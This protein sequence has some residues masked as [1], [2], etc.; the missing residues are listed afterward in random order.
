[1]VDGDKQTYELQ[2]YKYDVLKEYSLQKEEPLLFAV[3]WRNQGIWTINSIDSFSSKSSAYKISYSN[4]CLDD[5]SAI[6]GDYTYVFKH[7]CYRKSKFS[8]RENISTEFIH[9]HE[10]YG[11]TVHES[12]SID[13]VNFAPLCMLEPAVLDCAFNFKTTSRKKIF[14]DGTELI[15][16]LDG[17]PYVYKLSSLILAYLR[18]IQCY[19]PMDMYYKSNIVV[20]N[21][22]NI[23]DTVRQKC[24]G[25]RFYLVP[26]N[27]TDTAT[28]M[29]NLHFGS[30][31]H[32]M[33]AYTATKRVEGYRIIVSHK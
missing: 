28:K 33:E 21:A 18:K 2:K 8:N 7:P 22:F 24:G 26:H 12:L 3:F 23:V 1:M 16:E 17:T 30:V 5:L 32:I 20:E 9:C 11:R 25:E 15:E 6:F 13:G 31:K 4:A 10:K 29:I 19:S 27:I 14:E